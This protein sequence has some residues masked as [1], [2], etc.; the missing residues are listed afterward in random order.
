MASIEEKIGY[1][2]GIVEGM[3]DKQEQLSGRFAVL[4][5]NQQVILTTHKVFKGI[6]A[7]LLALLT[8]SLGDI[9]R[10]MKGI[11]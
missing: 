9:P 4:E 3:A 8:L 7:I 1:L 6:G 2:T 10:L 5:S 11:L